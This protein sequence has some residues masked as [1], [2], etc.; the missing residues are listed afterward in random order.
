MSPST[1]QA[2]WLSSLR[3]AWNRQSFHAR[4]SGLFF[5]AVAVWLIAA[6]GATAWWRRAVD[7]RVRIVAQVASLID[8]SLDELILREDARAHD[9]YNAVYRPSGVV[10][11]SDAFL[12]SP[13]AQPPSDPRVGAYFQ[14]DRPEKVRILDE[15]KR[16]DVA[17]AVRTMLLSDLLSSVRN[18]AFTPAAGDARGIQV[19][20]AQENDIYEQLKTGEKDAEKRAMLAFE[21]KLPRYQRKT[22]DTGPAKDSSG[23]GRVR[24]PGPRKVDKKGGNNDAVDAAPELSLSEVNYTSMSLERIDNV[25]AMHRNVSLGSS[26]VVQGL[27]LDNSGIDAWIRDLMDRR[28]AADEVPSLVVGDACRAEGTMT[29]PLLVPLDDRCL[30]FERSADIMPIGFLMLL[31]LLVTFAVWFV[32]KTAGRAELLARQKS[33]F[34]SS[35]SHELRTPLTTLRMHAELLR[36]GLVAPERRQRFHDDMVNESARLSALVE[37]VLEVARLEEGRRVLRVFEA[38]FGQLVHSMVEEQRRFIES[39]G[40]KLELSITPHSDDETAWDAMRGQVDRA[41]V[42]QILVNLLGNAVKYGKPMDGG[43]HVI[44]VDVTSTSTELVLRVR[45]DGRGIPT[46]D[47]EKVFERFHRVWLHDL[48]HVAGTGL[49]LYLVRELAAAHGGRA[50]IVGTERG[51]VV[52][53]VLPK[54]P[55]TTTLPEPGQG[56]DDDEVRSG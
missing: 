47:H 14:F 17:H 39:R 26:Q 19:V 42:E 40:C 32:D 28:I 15:A 8:E 18:R 33:T 52:E 7:K 38:D 27:L 46:A 48:S 2:P 43:A 53:V 1:S 22:V 9:Q 16:P 51:C 11:A 56:V 6:L 49:G 29:V 55:T 5:V 10:A 31:A 3:A 54:V 37:N 25:L 20:S 21:D 23:G 35:V 34:V 36:D 13:L 45:D 41:A 30:R 50:R 44:A 4:R 12:P 24:N